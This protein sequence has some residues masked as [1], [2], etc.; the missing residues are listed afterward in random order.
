[1]HHLVRPQMVRRNVLLHKYIQALSWCDTLPCRSLIRPA[2]WVQPLRTWRVSLVRQDRCHLLFLPLRLATNFTGRVESGLQG[3]LPPSESRNFQW[4]SSG[5]RAGVL[6]SREMIN[7]SP[8]IPTL[9]LSAFLSWCLSLM[10]AEMAAH[11]PDLAAPLPFFTIN[12]S[13]GSPV[14]CPGTSSRTFSRPTRGIGRQLW[15]IPL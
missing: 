2:L 7:P 15:Y 12:L 3:K 10:N 14:R 13:L 9:A 5:L 11:L 4:R 6:K 8:Y 1:M